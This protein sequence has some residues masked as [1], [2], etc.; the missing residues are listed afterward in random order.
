MNKGVFGCLKAEPSDTHTGL[1]E[2]EIAL[3]PKYLNN[4][5]CPS[6]WQKAEFSWFQGNYS[7]RPSEPEQDKVNISKK[8]MY[9]FQLE[10]SWL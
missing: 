7:I 2:L 4:E 5:Q 8:Q 6:S 9:L 10:N 3:L 1:A